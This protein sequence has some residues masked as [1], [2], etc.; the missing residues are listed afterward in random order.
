MTLANRVEAML[1]NAGNRSSRMMDDEEIEGMF[2][3]I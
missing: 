2:G 1:A 3:V